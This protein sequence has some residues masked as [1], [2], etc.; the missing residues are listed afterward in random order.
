MKIC[1]VTLESLTQRA[2]TIK[3]HSQFLAE[4]SKQK[5]C[6]CLTIPIIKTFFLISSLDRPSFSLNHYSLFYH[7]ILKCLSLTIFIFFS[8]TLLPKYNLKVYAAEKE[9]HA[10][11]N[12]DQATNHPNRKCWERAP[13]RFMHLTHGFRQ[14]F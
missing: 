9:N 1:I 8:G 4:L 11:H 7:N 13:L 6:Q 10:A 3:T 2:H 14:I 12:K 5:L